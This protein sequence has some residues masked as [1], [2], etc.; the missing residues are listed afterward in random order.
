MKFWFA[1]ALVGMLA[2]AGC[3]GSPSDSSATPSGTSVTVTAT[4]TPLATPALSCGDKTCVPAAPT[5]TPPGGCGGGE[6]EQCE[7]QAQS[8]AFTDLFARYHFPQNS[9]AVVSSEYVNWPDSCLGISTSGV[10]CLQVIT[11]GYRM[12]LR[13]ANTPFVEYHTDLS[14]R[15]VFVAEYATY[16]DVPPTQTPR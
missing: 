8:A 15:A 3:G 12:I 5:S 11:P 13:G 1:A 7:K 10:M 14:G 2:I 9:G 6:W 16:Q 4:E